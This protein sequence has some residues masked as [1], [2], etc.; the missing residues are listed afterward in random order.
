MTLLITEQGFRLNNNFGNTPTKRVDCKRAVCP[1]L[2]VLPLKPGKNHHILHPF[3]PFLSKTLRMDNGFGK[4][5]YILGKA[6]SVQKHHFL[7]AFTNS[8][9]YLFHIFGTKKPIT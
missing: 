2:R 7:N 3:P 4:Y 6:E 8:K 9:S 5:I 1:F